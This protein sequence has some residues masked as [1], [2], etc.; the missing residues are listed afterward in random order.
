MKISDRLLHFWLV[1]VQFLGMSF[2]KMYQIQWLFYWCAF[3]TL[4]EIVAYLCYKEE[5]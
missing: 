5:D 4:Y 1:I 3:W 2:A